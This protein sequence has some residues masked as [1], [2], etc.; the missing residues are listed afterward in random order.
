PRSVVALKGESQQRRRGRN[1]FLNLQSPTAIF[2]I[3]PAR[4]TGRARRFGLETGDA[5]PPARTT[6][7]S[8]DFRSPTTGAIPLVRSTGR[9]R[10]FRIRTSDATPPART[11]NVFHDSQSPK[12]G[13]I[14]PDVAIPCHGLR[15]LPLYANGHRAATR[16][17]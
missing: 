7:A 1:I 10:R 16:G 15:N 12:T 3:P 9:A 17:V 14:P 4:S 8:H 6:I 11:T 2:A 5:A 13:A